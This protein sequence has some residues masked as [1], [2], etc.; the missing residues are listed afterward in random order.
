VLAGKLKCVKHEGAYTFALFRDCGMLAMMSS[1]KDCQPVLPGAA[2][3]GVDTVT[4][5]E[6]EQFAVNHVRLGC[7]LAKN[8]AAAGRNLPVGAVAPRLCSDAM[9]T[10]ILSI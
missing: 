1:F 5:F 10:V 8:L 3:P 2:S 7:H 9:P 4:D 6:D